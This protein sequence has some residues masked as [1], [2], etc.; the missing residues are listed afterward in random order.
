MVSIIAAVAKNGVIGSCGRIP[1][2]I[3]EDM[4]YFRKVTMGGIVIMGRKT[5]EEIGRPLPER[6]NI[7]V[8]QSKNFSGDNLRTVRSLEEAI[9]LG[10]Q[11]A[12]E[13]EIPPRIFL[14][15]GQRIYSQGMKYSQRLYLTEI[16]AD[17]NGDA[18]FPELD[19]ERFRL[20]SK[21]IGKTPGVKFC[22]YETVSEK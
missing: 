6:F 3:P 18:F 17:Y 21:I 22:V 15:G 16:D 8:S 14:C 2:N 4:E 7:I 10:E 13:K 19:R 1:W 20:E 5:H 11:Y 9:S 12:S